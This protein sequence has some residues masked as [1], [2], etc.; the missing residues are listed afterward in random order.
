MTALLGTLAANHGCRLEGLDHRL[1]TLASLSRK[2][3][4]K[5]R[6]RTNPGDPAADTALE[7]SKM[8]DVLRYTMIVPVG[9][10]GQVDAKLREE[11]VKLT[12]EVK[13][14]WNAWSDPNAKAYKGVNMTFGTSAGQLFELQL[15][16]EASFATKQ[17]I[18]AE[19]EEWRAAETT[20]E[21]RAELILVMAAEWTNVQVP[22]G[23]VPTPKGQPT[24][25][26][27]KAGAATKPAKPPAQPKPEKKT[28]P[29]LKVLLAQAAQGLATRAELEEGRAWIKREEL[30]LT[31]DQAAP[32]KADRLKALKVLGDDIGFAIDRM[33]V[34]ESVKQG[35]AIYLESGTTKGA[36]GGFAA[37][38]DPGRGFFTSG[39]PAAKTEG[40]R[41]GLDDAEIAALGTY[42][43]DDYKYIN[44]ATAFSKTWLR[45][46]M[47][48]ANQ[49]GTERQRLEEGGTHAAVM[50]MAI[51]KLPVWKGATFRGE[52][53]SQKE[54][55]AKFLTRPDGTVRARS[56]TDK[57]LAF[58][59]MSRLREKGMAFATGGAGTPAGDQTIHVLY[60][61][62]VRDARDIQAFSRLD[63]AEVL[64]PPGATFKV[65]K[66]VTLKTGPNGN[67]KATA[68]YEVHI[69]QQ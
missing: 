1:K 56:T 12:H 49:T 28:Y 8:N 27:A 59:S 14:Y 58:T 48:K 16:T 26:P 50:S 35:K 4:D 19:Y 43:A 31:S 17:A 37:I 9:T 55:D 47:T 66:V 52:R 67:P 15:H 2:L 54:F 44:P 30:R 18:H 36:E 41:H 29:R 53:M 20:A 10:Y 57:R 68:W 22:T 11:I 51:A 32:D 13:G 24:T 33:R 3:A 38:T 39:K 40:A 5:V 7:A 64:C 65:T 62:K 42:T 63:E 23:A 45:D 60:L 6:R 69:T 61:I 25:G 21:R 46:N 34:D